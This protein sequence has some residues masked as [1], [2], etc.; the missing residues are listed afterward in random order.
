MS[1]PE[2]E[3]PA[4]AGRPSRDYTNAIHPTNVARQL[5][6][7]RAASRRLAPLDCGCAD[8]WPC[9]CTQLAMS[10]HMV[11]AGRDAAHHVLSAGC[12]PIL[13]RHLLAELWRRDGA[14]RGLA[15][16]LHRLTGGE[17]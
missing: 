5:R 4:L 10:E 8:P 11:D 16:L 1:P 6:T 13:A 7:R 17:T 12:T 9:H 2:R 14:D 3:K 15:E